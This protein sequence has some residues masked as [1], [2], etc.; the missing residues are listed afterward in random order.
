M[1]N[2]DI[3]LSFTKGAHNYKIGN[4]TCSPFDQRGGVLAH[5][6]FPNNDGHV[7][8]IH[9]DEAENWEYC[10]KKPGD[11]QT[12]LFAVLVHEIG[13]SLGIGHSDVGDTIMSPF[14]TYPDPF[15][16]Q[17]DDILAIE[18]LYGKKP[19]VTLIPTSTPPPPP[20]TEADDAGVD[21]TPANLVG[22]PI[23]TLSKRIEEERGRNSD[24]FFVIIESQLY[25]IYGN[26]AW[27]RDLRH[28]HY[29]KYS[30]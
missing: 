2:S 5:A 22:L 1:L 23:C 12:S 26:Y 13:H 24:T 20:P 6:Q 8:E 28:G 18:K 21:E 25:I 10:M 19:S 7:K 30:D 16:L 27:I 3:L 15:D 11:K 29:D 9:L 14:Y 4:L 17:E